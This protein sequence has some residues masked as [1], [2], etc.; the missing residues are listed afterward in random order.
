[1]PQ[2]DEVWL[3]SR[4]LRE[5]HLHPDIRRAASLTTAIKTKAL[6][7]IFAGRLG[8]VPAVT[9]LLTD[10]NRNVFIIF[11]PDC[12]TASPVMY[13]VMVGINVYRSSRILNYF[14]GSCGRGGPLRSGWPVRR[15][16]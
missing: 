7:I 2:G 11:P 8:S 4:V 15:R 14:F 1:M 16:R 9:T 6:R 3:I 12:V 10:N 13:T 5:T